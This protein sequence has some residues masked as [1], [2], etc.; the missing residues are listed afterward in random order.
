MFLEK[1]DVDGFKSYSTKTTIGPFSANFNCIS[2]LNGSGKSNILDAITFVIGCRDL[3]LMRCTHL[4]DLIYKQ[5]NAHIKRAS[6]SLTFNNQD[7]TKS[8]AGFENLDE[9]IVTRICSLPNKTKYLLNGNSINNVNIHNLFASI[10]LNPATPN[11]FIIFQGKITKI[12]MMKPHELSLL[13]KEAAGT[14]HY[15][16]RKESAEKVLSKKDQKVQ[17]IQDTLENDLLPKI[18]QYQKQR[19]DYMELKRVSVEL[20]EKT[21]YVMNLEYSLRLSHFEKVDAEYKEKE[22]HIEQLTME[23]NL[24]ASK[25]TEILDKMKLLKTK[26]TTNLVDKSLERQHK[27]TQNKITKQETNL[28]ML[29]KDL[30]VLSQEKCD[31]GKKLADL[32]IQFESHLHSKSDVQRQFDQLKSE[33]ENSEQQLQILSSMVNGELDVEIERINQ[34]LKKTHSAFENVQN[35]LKLLE[36]EWG[37]FHKSRFDKADKHLRDLE[38]AKSRIIDQSQKITDEIRHFN[39]NDPLKLEDFKS[40]VQLLLTGL[41]AQFGNFNA[42]D[43]KHDQEV[44]KLEQSFKQVESQIFQLKRPLRGVYFLQDLP[45]KYPNL[46]NNI[47]GCIGTF[48]SC[49]DKFNLAISIAGGNK[50]KHCVVSTDEVAAFILKNIKLEMRTSFV[51]MNTLQSKSITMSKVEYAKRISDKIY[52]V[53]DII[54]YP[55]EYR[56][57]IDYCFGNV[58]FAE[59]SKVAEQV[60]F[61]KNV[62]MKC[63]TL[64][65]DVYDPSGTVS[66]GGKPKELLMQRFNQIHILENQMSTLNLKKDSVQQAKH[67]LQTKSRT[68]HDYQLILQE[69]LREF[70][71]VEKERHQGNHAQAK[72]DGEE[73]LKLLN[74]KKEE[75]LEIQKELESCQNAQKLTKQQGNAQQIKQDIAKVQ[76]EYNFA[77]KNYEIIQNTYENF[78]SVEQQFDSDIKNCESKFSELNFQSQELN[79]ERSKIELEL[80]GLKSK[81]VTI[82]ETYN[83][84]IAQ[85]NEYKHE[86]NILNNSKQTY[87]SQVEDLE[88]KE[89]EITHQC[90]VWRDELSKTKKRIVELEKRNPLKI[91]INDNLDSQKEE[92]DRLQ[93]LHDKL[94]VNVN[95]Q[96]MSMID[97]AEQEEL[98]LGGMLKTVQ[99][100]KIKIEGAIEELDKHK[101]TA[102]DST[103]KQVTDSFGQI[104]AG[105]LPGSTARLVPSPSGVVDGCEI[106]VQLNSKWKESLSELSGGQRSLV[107]ISLILSL[108]KFKTSPLYV[109]DE[110]DAGTLIFI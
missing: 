37:S 64:Q 99:S 69:K 8:P 17:E 98:K 21:K 67:K 24:L 18:Q 14:L 87:T 59:S 52:S 33:K 106:K 81:F 42:Q 34:K 62:L 86:I 68:L 51:P 71:M 56:K 57:C 7:K 3:S 9:I 26:N 70:T 39:G 50:L 100:D 1:I 23:K 6:V 97:V 96:V 72:L 16:Q 107:A 46:K 47:F 91:E 101:L 88:V 65:G 11:N 95:Q 103:W 54:N 102:V 19:N 40:Q 22:I 90:K 78:Q 73:H 61:D 63:I 32:K 66:G 60:A 36:K 27:D 5:G 53:H 105:I 76:H 74:T 94:K 80:Q 15:E 58:L 84:A 85:S 38:Q 4:S 79:R 108:L 13:L 28:N 45:L 29:L 35:E 12:I 41:T 25:I 48:I 89:K 82:E 104:L 49:D 44:K 110:V 10:G 2:G 31:E 43:L 109:L 92:L 55:E 75:F 93:E 20:E 77:L 83:Q 30:S